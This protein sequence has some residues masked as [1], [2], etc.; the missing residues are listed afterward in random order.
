MY[1]DEA[2]MTLRMRTIPVTQNAGHSPG[3]SA[4][5][6]DLTIYPQLSLQDL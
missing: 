1:L 5:N 2:R 6:K 3:H 4:E